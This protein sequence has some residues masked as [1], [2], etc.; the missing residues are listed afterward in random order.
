MRIPLFG[1][2]LLVL[3]AGCCKP[4]QIVTQNRVAVDGPVH[5]TTLL[6]TDQAPVNDHGPVGSMPLAGDPKGARVAVLDVDGLLLNADFTGPY[7]NGENP[8]GLFRERLE[9]VA[10]DEQ[11]AAVVLRINSPGGSVNAAG[12]MHRDLLAFRAHT[13]K[14]VVACLVGLGTGTAYVLAAAADQVCADPTTVT[15]GVGVILNLYNLRELMAQFNV[16]PQTIKAGAKTDLGSPT[17]KLTDEERQLLEAMAE[18]FHQYLQKQV[19]HSRP[20][21]DRAGGTTFDGRVFTATQAQA[22]GLVDRVCFLDD[23]VEWAR[24]LGHCPQAVVTFYHRPNDPAR[25]LYAETPNVPLQGA[26]I[27]PSLPGLD[28]SRLPVFLSVWQPEVTL[29][30][31]GGR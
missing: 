29:E 6:T 26:G 4:L 25:S 2:V 23:A 14:P 1:S 15:G 9:A 12:L 13:H 22:R 27:L 30:R 17:R 16:I 28:R 10:A 8:V 18:E 11:V 21:I 7:S 24:E 19:L 3:G 20:G 31:L 5:T